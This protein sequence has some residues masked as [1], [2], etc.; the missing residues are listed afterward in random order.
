MITYNDLYET[1]RKERYSKQLQ[2]L[3]KDF[4]N[5]VVDYL[6]EKREIAN[7]EED[8]FSDV[9][10]KTKK[11]LENAMTLFREIILVR[12]KKILDLVLVAAEVGISR[13][14]FDNMLNFE[15]TLFEEMMKC[16]EKSERSVSDSLNGGN[17]VEEKNELIVFREYVEE[18]VDLEG[19]KNG[20]FEKGDIANISKETAKILIE[21]GRAEVVER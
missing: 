21:D 15:K 11:Q 19:G 20:P 16:I 17:S 3:P 5:S 8:V 10:L 12:R 14:D 1:A 18:F 2:K 4:I 7:R 9:V 6:R 13:Q